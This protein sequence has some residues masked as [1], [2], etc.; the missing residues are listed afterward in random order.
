ASSS[1]P[2][3]GVGKNG[4]PASWAARTPGTMFGGE[5]R[6]A[7]RASRR[8]RPLTPG[9]EARYGGSPL[10]ATGRSSRTSRARY[11]TP[12]PP[13]PS[14]RCTAYCD[15]SADQS[16]PNSEPAYTGADSI[17]AKC[18]AKRHFPSRGSGQALERGS[19]VAEVRVET[20]GGLVLRA[21]AACVAALL[22]N[23]AE[24]VVSMGLRRRRLKAGRTEVFAHRRLAALELLSGKRRGF[25][26]LIRGPRIVRRRAQPGVDSGEGVCIPPRGLV[27]AKQ[28]VEGGCAV[29]MRR[30]QRCVLRCRRREI[31][32]VPFALRAQQAAPISVEPARHLRLC[33]R[34]LCSSASDGWSVHIVRGPSFASVEVRRL[35]LDRTVELRART[36]RE[37]GL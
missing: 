31:L 21:G 2:R 32:K 13:R 1:P 34:A 25:P 8:N 4:G 12:I 30:V 19:G 17:R 29:R 14:S 16:S 28:P 6:P 35:Q 18:T 15:A 22:E 36:A 9:S 7:V 37:D 24:A 5:S 20:R 3:N 33:P 23:H 10:I 11:T 26:E 27:R